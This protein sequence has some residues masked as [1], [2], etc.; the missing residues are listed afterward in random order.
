MEFCRRC[1]GFGRL[2]E[3][4]PYNVLC[5]LCGGCG[6]M[7]EVSLV[8]TT[9]TRERKCAQEMQPAAGGATTVE[10]CNLSEREE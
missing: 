8:S 7:P 3:G 10:R 1:Y 2:Y 5:P 9:D 4:P 6:V